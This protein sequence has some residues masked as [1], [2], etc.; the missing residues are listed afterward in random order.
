[1][2]HLQHRIGGDVAA[3]PSRDTP[4]ILD[5]IIA[6]KKPVLTNI[7]MDNGCASLKG[8][9]NARLGL[10]LAVPGSLFGI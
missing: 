8:Q 1:M 5:N 4:L 7:G 9:T 10:L 3:G 6:E 2:F